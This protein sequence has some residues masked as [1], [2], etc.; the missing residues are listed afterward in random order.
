[1]ADTYLRIHGENRGAL[2]AIRGTQRGLS[3]LDQSAHKSGR[4]FGTLA[5]I[6]KTSAI[7]IGAIGV[8]A[9][10][11]AISVL[12]AAG[13]FEQSLNTF[14]AVSAATGDQMRE[15]SRLAKDLGADLTIPGA[16]AAD[17]A[18]AM[19]ELA[20]GGLSVKDSMAAAKGTLQLAAAAEVENGEAA[21]IA[22]RALNSFG[23]AGE[24]AGRVADLLAGAANA[25]TA[26]MSDMAY[27]LS[28]SSAVAHQAGLSI[29]QTVAALS[30]LANAGIVG[31]DAGTSLRTM[32]QRLTPQ[33]E[34]AANAMADLGVT[35]FDS[36]GNWR[37]FR[38]IVDDYAV[39]LGKLTPKQ[40]TAALQ[41]IF[42][43][44]AVRA[45]NIIFGEGVDA[46]D[47]MSK[48]TGRQGAAAD[49]AAAKMKGYQGALEG[50][51]SA[52]ETAS[53][54][55]GSL[56]L[57]TATAAIQALGNLVNRFDA[58]VEAASG[59]DW[60]G[61][62]NLGTTL[63][64]IAN[65]TGVFASH[66]VDIE[67]FGNDVGKALSVAGDA[68]RDRFGTVADLAIR[69]WPGVRDAVMS[70][71]SA[72]GRIVGVVMPVVSDLVKRVGDAFRED[73]GPALAQI[74]HGFEAMTPFLENVVLPILK[75]IAITVL[76]TVVVAFKILA[77]VIETIG[78]ILGWIGTKA[79]PLRG[80]F[81][82]LGKVVGI[83]FFG[84]ALKVVGLVAGRL[85]PGLTKTIEFVGKVGGAFKTAGGFLS[86]VFGPAIG[87][88]AKQFAPFRIALG[89]VRTSLATIFS[90]F[91]RLLDI[92]SRIGG[93]FGDVGGKLKGA[94]G[95]VPGTGDG[96]M[97]VA[98]SAVSAGQGKT[99]NLIRNLWPIVGYAKSIGGVV[100]STY[101][102][103]AITS[104]G[105]PSLHGVNPSQAVDI[106]G[107][108]TTM[109]SIFRTAQRIPGVSEV[110]LNPW[111]WK[112][113]RISNIAGTALGRD[114]VDHVH[115]G[116]GGV[117]DGTLH[118]ATSAVA[119]GFGIGE[120]TI[121]STPR[122]W[123]RVDPRVVRAIIALSSRFKIDP[124][125]AM[126][127]AL[128]EGGLRFGSIGDRGTSFGPFMLHEGGAL[129]KGSGPGFA[130]SIKGIEYAL[131]RMAEAG[132]RGLRG[133]AAIDAIIR[134]FERPA[135]PGASV[136]AAS[137][138]YSDVARIFGSLLGGGDDRAPRR[139]AVAR[140]LGAG[141][142][143]SSV[144][145]IE[146]RVE[147]MKNAILGM[148]RGPFRQAIAA[149]FARIKKAI[150]KIAS[151]EDR[152]IVSDSLNA[153][154]ERISD[155][156]A[157]VEEANAAALERIQ[158]QIQNAR[159]A[160]GDAWGDVMGRAFEV[161][162]SR[163]REMVERARV[164]V[165]G[166]FGS[167]E[168]GEG[169][170]TPTRRL[171]RERQAAKDAAA[172]ERELAEARAAVANVDREMNDAEAEVIRTRDEAIAAAQREA[173]GV[174]DDLRFRFGADAE[175][176][177]EYLSA[178]RDR[179]EAIRA[180]EKDATDE[181]AR[182][183]AD[184][185]NERIER[186]ERL[187][188]LLY[189][190]ETQRMEAIA[191]AEEQA[192]D[193]AL[194]RERARIEDERRIVRENFEAR[195]G[196]IVTAFQ[197]EEI[198][199][200]EANE[201]ILGLLRDYDVDYAI[202]G[203]LVGN[204]FADAFIAAMQR[205]AAAVAIVTGASGGGDWITSEAA[206]ISGETGIPQSRIE[207]ILRTPETADGRQ[208]VV[209]SRTV[210]FQHGGRVR[211]G[212][213]RRMMPGPRDVVPSLL[214]P[215]EIVLT[216]AMQSNVAA[217]LAGRGGGDVHVHLHNPTI[218][219]SRLRDAALDIRNVLLAHK[220]SNVNLGMS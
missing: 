82:L 209:G 151:P 107:P 174:L 50:F 148:D 156:N 140:I 152:Q 187:D 2:S 37:D 194:E 206:R 160:V 31:S 218:L 43:A 190:M 159:D 208:A 84:A 34:K 1:M 202:A 69:A 123:G 161:F 163:T 45:A 59:A 30:E 175:Q 196:E 73:L 185:A 203:A 166:A 33:T 179:D 162:D 36:K 176:V 195:Y 10:A 66:S 64:Q 38:D 48:A 199:A 24:D 103:G 4:S 102:P 51:H 120:G 70:A 184:F 118:A 12:S 117:G 149:Q 210:G 147:R 44:D 13:K 173:Q 60:T 165:S 213:R 144:R 220:S 138:R 71:F 85:I 16:S 25:S 167:F 115:V 127:V 63:A 78:R 109:E 168:F 65:L 40:R 145:A 99:A 80:T 153:L 74:L 137:G 133:Q 191:A 192:A 52:V 197:N 61:F 100:T 20:K 28:Q 46:F 95:W 180:A 164:M 94:F 39:A 56:L 121:P 134:K 119:G 21:T 171:L 58:F 198:S 169:E 68:I 172:A 157:K 93:F 18:V 193:A 141:V 105:N 101:R 216:A 113:G 158:E 217:A 124:F 126:A 104:S 146:S 11:A 23:L 97:A 189:E 110:I 22:A 35:T 186:Q 106:S 200:A 42:G 14:Q 116:Y 86:R 131:R 76:Q 170:E 135:A 150:T 108:R 53:I 29:E 7:A 26:E 188:D 178:V 81:E 122:S 77:P 177:P 57:P 75:G 215:D 19:T 15:V 27:A 183:R 90:W 142:D 214:D 111:L 128:G 143:E 47:A 130:N 182:I 155:H 112:R 205:A 139:S 67:R 125:A 181:I 17:A 91:K 62:E 6:A 32:L 212:L 207:E 54:T 79:E 5:G 55:I 114:H 49:L 154:F 129:P 92:G 132:A 219:G 136:S 201:R 3:G 88:V 96:V 41:T 89:A 204:A 83:V 87:I 8:A 9:G 72:I 98:N 211:D